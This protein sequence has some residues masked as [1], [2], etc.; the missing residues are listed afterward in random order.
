MQNQLFAQLS[1]DAH[2]ARQVLQSSYVGDIHYVIL[3]TL[4]E[5][6]ELELADRF[7]ELLRS[8]S[9]SQSEWSISLRSLDL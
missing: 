1:T 3:K 5:L 4:D 9:F 7:R 8:S 6:G 2:F